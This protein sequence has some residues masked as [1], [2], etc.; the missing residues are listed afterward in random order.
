MEGGLWEMVNS[1]AQSR[2]SP[3]I[4]LLTDFGLVDSYV[5]EMKAIILSIC[6]SAK[7]LDISHLVEKFNIRMGAFLLASA[8]P[9][10][11][12]G[13][14]HVGVVDPGVGSERRPIV[15]RTKRSLFVGPDNGLL[16]PA[17]RAES[18]LHVYEISN[19]SMMMDEVSVTFH[20]RDVFAAVA[21][22]L[23]CGTPE[24]ECGDEIMDY[25]RPSLTEPEFD[26]K[27]AVCE[28][29]HV[30]GFGNVLTN[31]PRQLLS[32]L[33]VKTGGKIKVSIG[34]RRLSIGQV[35]TY[36]DLKENEF[37]LLIGSHGFLEIACKETSAARRLGAK[38][39]VTI[40][41]SCA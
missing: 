8:A 15:V 6:P 28:V 35:H 16:I 41:L 25:L 24:E 26:G 27:T 21:A 17:A 32:E 34:K 30:D 33:N 12:A 1:I 39:G 31:L 20:G 23:A 19:R 29:L 18:I 38:V 13:A 40:R 3:L 36:S 14:T 11:P 22:H 5:S 7:I 9:A 2:S 37:G 4:S 10:F